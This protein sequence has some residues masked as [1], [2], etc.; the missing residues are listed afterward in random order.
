[1]FAGVV[2]ATAALLGS[3]VLAAPAQAA[4]QALSTAVDAG[5]VKA[6]AVTGFNPENIIS[7][8][9]F[10]DGNAMSSADI[11]AF[12]DARIGG[13][14]NGKCLNV[15]NASI[16]SRDAWYSA[17]TGDLVCSA[18]QGGT[19]RVS[20][21][22]YRVQ[23]A[24]GISAKVIL[25]TLQK[26][27]GLTTSSAPSDWNLQAAMGASCPDTAPCDPAYSGV[28]PQIV[29]GVR[30]LKIYKAGRFAK[31]PGVNFIGYSPNSSCGGTNLNIQNYATA[32]LYNYTPYQPNAA[33]LAAGW[34][35][36]DGCSSY[37]NRNFFNY[38]TS[39]FG[40]TTAVPSALIRSASAPTVYLA[41]GTK[42]YTVTDVGDYVELARVYGAAAVVSDSYLSFVTDAGPVTALLRDETTQDMWL[43]QGGQRHKLL[44]CASVQEWGSTCAA[45]SNVSSSMLNFIPIGADV[46]DFFTVRGTT[47]WGRMESASVVTPLWD[48]AAA[49]SV[50][51]G[52]TPT[53]FDISPTLYG[54][55]TKKALQFAPGQLVRSNENV[56]VYFTADSSKLL[57]V[58][59]W[60]DVAA[61]G[62]SASNIAFVPQAQLLA[63]YSP[64][65]TVTPT[66]R[67]D[68]VTYIA[69][70]GQLVRLTDPARA[71]LPTTDVTA[72]TCAAF[73][74]AA[75]PVDGPLFVK[76]TSA[77]WVYL[78]E[79][80]ATRRVSAWAAL[81]A[82]SG[83]VVPT[84]LTVPD[85]FIAALSVGAP[86]MDGL[87][88]KI[89]T[90][91]TLSL[92]SGATRNAIASPAAAADAGI[93]LDYT[94]VSDADGASLAAGATLGQW[95][96][97][98]DSTW[99][100]GGGG[101]T[102]VTAEAAT[103]FTPA[104]LSSATCGRI[105]VSS[106]S[107]PLPKVFVKAK[108]G[109]QV[110]MADGG[111]YR[112]VPDWATLLRVTGGT[113]PPILVMSD[114][115]FAGLSKGAPVS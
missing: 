83:G 16:S 14:G 113:V 110:Y 78:I 20:E 39:W 105:P 114:D 8:A 103:G 87:I 25:V 112:L 100:V 31:Q 33:S 11:Q 68:G 19:M 38:Y 89:G 30:Q 45:P 93:V 47:Q 82:A 41:T 5:I 97:C 56:Q 6:A 52:V 65:G 21:L 57:A 94:A 88:V 10:Y 85:Q 108:G 95:V 79:Q 102:A 69:S 101:R 15:L 49:R 4:P 50:N 91:P 62:R 106:S 24:C 61:Y 53:A 84:I 92:V 64:A 76:S 70:S 23:V 104:A 63:G 29:Q 42:R 2:A 72:V 18:L 115:V 81:L 86:V 67:C 109:P 90:G 32:A 22:I 96:R 12:L 43:I 80:G 13:C 51:G 34:G 46:A 59:A 75:T 54:K 58:N 1:M 111:V 77:D 107:A 40:S 9:L 27:Q 74:I 48:A 17:V 98:G 7:D 55:K 3:L 26:E 66:L 35:L 99:F 44:T 37:G 28:G 60:S 71:G 36:G 73:P